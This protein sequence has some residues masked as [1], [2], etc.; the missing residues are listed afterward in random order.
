M[1]R[2][3]SNLAVTNRTKGNPPTEVLPF[4]PGGE[5]SGTFRNVI[6]APEERITASSLRDVSR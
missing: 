1:S 2:D 4:G 5:G 3:F 6:P